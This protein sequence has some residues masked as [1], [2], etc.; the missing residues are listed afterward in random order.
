[1][2]FTVIFS[3]KSYR[4]IRS[5]D[6]ELKERIQKAVQEISN[7]PWEKGTIKVKGYDDVRRKRVG[8]FRIIYRIDQARKEILVA[9]IA[10]RNEETY[11][12]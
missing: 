11:K 3:P 12:F 4:K 8:D 10:R 9:F 1:M 7:D 2:S 5:F 6:S